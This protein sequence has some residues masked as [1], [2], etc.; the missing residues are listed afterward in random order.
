MPTSVAAVVLVMKRSHL[1][2]PLA[3]QAS[4]SSE[5][6]ANKKSICPSSEHQQW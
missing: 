3:W 5:L 1:K 2:D 6:T 4:A